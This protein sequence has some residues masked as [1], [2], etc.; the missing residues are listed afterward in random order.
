MDWADDIA[1]SVHD[2]EDGVIAGRIDLRSLADPSE[3]RALAE[4]GASE[5]RGW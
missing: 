4:L 5:F 1:Y 3:Q 2:V